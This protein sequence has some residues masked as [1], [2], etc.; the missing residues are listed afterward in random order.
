MRTLAARFGYLGADEDPGAWRP[1]GVIDR[2][3]DLLPWLAL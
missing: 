3:E 2:P 1:D